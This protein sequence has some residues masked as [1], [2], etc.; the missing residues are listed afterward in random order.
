V[1]VDEAMLHMLSK[2]L[3]V[4]RHHGEVCD[5]L[6]MCRHVDCIRRTTSNTVG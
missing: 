4:A 6:A 1:D 5:T 2:R 3:E